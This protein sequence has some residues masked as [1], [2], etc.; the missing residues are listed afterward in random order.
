M[1]E[2]D[3]DENPEADCR[4]TPAQAELLDKLGGALSGASS[5]SAASADSEAP[6]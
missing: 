2:H 5:G 4:L 6:G 3:R 1:G